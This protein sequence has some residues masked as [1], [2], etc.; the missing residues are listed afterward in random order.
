MG[1]T[2]NQM[3]LLRRLL[4]LPYESGYFTAH[5]SHEPPE[6]LRHRENGSVWFDPALKCS[7]VVVEGSQEYKDLEMGDEDSESKGEDGRAKGVWWQRAHRILPDPDDEY[8]TQASIPRKRL[9]AGLQEMSEQAW[10]SLNTVEGDEAQVSVSLAEDVWHVLTQ[11]VSMSRLL[12]LEVVLEFVLIFTF[13]LI[14]FLFATVENSAPAGESAGSVFVSKL[15]LSLTSVRL[16][17]DSIFGW[18]SQDA[19]TGLE[20]AVLALQGWLHWLLLCVAS[21]VIVARALKPLRQVVFSPD[22]VLT[23]DFLQIR[24]QVIRH[25]TVT[26]HNV[27]ATLQ[28]NIGGNMHSLKLRNDLDGWAS[29]NGAAPMTI[30]HNI[31]EASPFHPSRG[32]AD[33][34]WT[35]RVN[36]DATDNNGG[37]VFST[38]CYYKP[39][40]FLCN[41]KGFKAK[42]RA[43][44]YD[45]YPRILLNHKFL[46]QIRM[47]RDKDG[48][49][50]HLE[51]NPFLAVNID[52]LARTQ[53]IEPAQGM[54]APLGRTAM[55]LGP[56]P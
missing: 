13:A 40:T 55:N 7:R 14:L 45:V 29:W 49:P 32:I 56:Q 8:A 28:A 38:M 36:I 43:A 30:Q 54:G 34:L 2:S 33:R 39:G 21:A 18:K 19:S 11:D 23:D 51:K 3:R 50:Q 22:C 5:P 12:V 42:F 52:N 9:D 24:M 46:D 15:L 1:G 26:L 41:S 20:V 17:T 25:Q 10:M 48:K 53:L 27:K 31:D 35:V 44:G 16:S 4:G 6:G 37:Q 47:F